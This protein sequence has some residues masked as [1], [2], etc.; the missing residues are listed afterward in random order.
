MEST[1][2]LKE[3]NNSMAE[4]GQISTYLKPVRFD[5]SGILKRTH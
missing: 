3:K 5:H 1:Q 2:N 4:S